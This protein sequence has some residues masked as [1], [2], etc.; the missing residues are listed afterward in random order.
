MKIS[1]RDRWLQFITWSL[2]T[3]MLMHATTN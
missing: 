1:K 3:N 2:Q